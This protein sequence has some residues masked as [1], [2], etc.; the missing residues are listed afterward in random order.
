MS[1]LNGWMINMVG[2]IKAGGGPCRRQCDIDNKTLVC[3]SCGLNYK[4]VKRSD[5]NGS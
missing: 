4:P 5:K 1:H 3:K 2:Y